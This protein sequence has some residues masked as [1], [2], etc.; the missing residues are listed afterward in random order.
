MERQRQGSLWAFNQLH[1]LSERFWSRFGK[2]PDPV[3]PKSE[4][5]SN[6]NADDV[7]R[8]VIGECRLKSKDIARDVENGR[9]DRDTDA[10]DDEEECDL[11]RHRST[12]SILPGPES[13]T[14]VGDQDRDH[15]SNE[16][17]CHWAVR[18]GR[19]REVDQEIEDGEVGDI[20]DGTNAAELGQFDASIDHPAQHEG[21]SKVGRKEKA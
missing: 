9:C 5:G 6:P 17:T 20:G 16:G 3:T 12:G 4:D 7:R 13:I 1:S 10:I 8:D 18:H 15:S 11:S 21:K 14:E 19:E 2:D